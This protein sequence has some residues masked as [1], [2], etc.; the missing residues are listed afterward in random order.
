MTKPIDIDALVRT[1][2]R[3]LGGKRLEA[4]AVV[5]AP[6]GKVAAEPA[7]EAAAAPV[8]EAALAPVVSRLA[9]QARLAPIIRKFVERLRERLPEAERAVISRDARELASFAHWL[10]G[11]AGSMGYDAFTEPALEL[12]QAAKAGEMERAAK[13]F[14]TVRELARRMVPPQQET[15]AA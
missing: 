7:A 2:A 14:A 8:A 10:K 15:A 6:A 4:D 5:R 13:L 12:E 9:G 11:S 3:L 1:L